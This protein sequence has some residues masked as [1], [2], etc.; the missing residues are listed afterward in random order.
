MLSAY[1]IRAAVTSQANR[2][3]VQVKKTR[4]EH[5]TKKSVAM[6]CYDNADSPGDDILALTLHELVAGDAGLLEDPRAQHRG[7]VE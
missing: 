6:K 2:A 1:G 3:Q 5:K 7:D 4:E